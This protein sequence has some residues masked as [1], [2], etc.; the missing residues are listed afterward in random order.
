M[1][2]NTPK[3]TAVTQGTQATKTKNKNVFKKKKMVAVTPTLE[4]F[5]VRLPVVKK[6][7]IK[8]VEVEPI[9]VI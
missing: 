8:K 7:E 9:P 5:P 4:A 6:P 1:E 3:K 2:V